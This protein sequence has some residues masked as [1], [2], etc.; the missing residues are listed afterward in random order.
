MKM[1]SE[2]WRSAFATRAF[3]LS[4]LLALLPLA[5]LIVHLDEQ[6]SRGF[7]GETIGNTLLGLLVF[8]CL[9]LAVINF[10]ALIYWLGHRLPGGFRRLVAIIWIIVFFGCLWFFASIVEENHYTLLQLLLARYL[11]PVIFTTLGSMTLLIVVIHL[12][13]WVIAGFRERPTAIDRKGG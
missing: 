5:A 4:W 3:R 13:L 2:Y 9:Y 11:P 6:R 8:Y 10:A 12:T 1:L 7:P